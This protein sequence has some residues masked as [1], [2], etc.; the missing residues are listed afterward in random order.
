MIDGGERHTNTFFRRRVV[1]A[2]EGMT[3]RPRL[4]KGSSNGFSVGY[5]VPI[6]S[7]FTDHNDMVIWPW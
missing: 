3:Y 5:I 1:L 2:A 4:L 6:G 7:W